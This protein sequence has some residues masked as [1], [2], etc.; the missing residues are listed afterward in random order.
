M[1]LIDSKIKQAD[2]DLSIIEDL[3]K[4]KIICAAMEAQPDL[5]FL[6]KAGKITICGF[7]DTCDYY[8]NQLS[9]I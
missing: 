1:L 9:D 7:A 3:P 5:A 2:F 8:Y 6:I 4:L